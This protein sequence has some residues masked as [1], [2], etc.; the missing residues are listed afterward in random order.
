MRAASRPAISL[1]SADAA[2]TTPAG[3]ADSASEA[4]TSTYGVI[5]VVVGVVGLGDVD[6]GR[7]GSL[8]RVGQPFGGAG[9]AHHDGGGLAQCACGGD[10]FGGDLLD[11]TFSVLDEHK[12]FSHVSSMSFVL[13]GVRG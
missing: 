1:P 2:S 11:R 6:L 10:Q 4:S 9:L 7:T 3:L 12:Y 5:E 8:E 13:F